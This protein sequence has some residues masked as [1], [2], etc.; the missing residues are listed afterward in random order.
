MTHPEDH[1]LEIPLEGLA[2]FAG[3]GGQRLLDPQLRSRLAALRSRAHDRSRPSTEAAT[4]CRPLRRDG[5]GRLVEYQ[6]HARAL[7]RYRARPRASAHASFRPGPR[8]LQRREVSLSGALRRSR[9]RDALAPSR[10]HRGS[11]R[12]ALASLAACRRLVEPILRRSRNSSRRAP[13][14]LRYATAIWSTARTST[15]SR[16]C[17]ARPRGARFRFLGTC[18]SMTI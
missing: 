16:R 12:R 5:Y 17:G 18:H 13:C 14:C 10:R 1:T 2:T 9:L 11:I 7:R 8:R 15:K 4:C 6:R 3:P